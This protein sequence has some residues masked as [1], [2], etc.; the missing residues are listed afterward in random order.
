MCEGSRAWP[1][2]EWTWGRAGAWPEQSLTGRSASRKACPDTLRP[3]VALMV[4]FFLSE[5][6]EWFLFLL[7]LFLI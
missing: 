4:F 7:F 3:D 2:M 1:L 6:T 5:F